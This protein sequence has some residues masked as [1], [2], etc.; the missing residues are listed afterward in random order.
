MEKEAKMAQ[1]R[2]ELENDIMPDNELYTFD[3]PALDSRPWKKE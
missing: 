2:W 1:Q 3:D